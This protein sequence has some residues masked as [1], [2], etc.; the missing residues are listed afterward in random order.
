MELTNEEKES[1]DIMDL[2][3]F[4]QAITYFILMNFMTFILY[5]VDKYK[6]KHKRFRIPETTLLLCGYL[7]G[8]YGAVIGMQLW[9]HK[10][11]KWKFRIAV[12]VSAVF[13]TVVLLVLIYFF[14]I[15]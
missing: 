14:R 9:H 15:G 4:K 8:A 2:L 13:V 10:T 7:G 11:R 12:P 6:A 5:G 3:L 1:N